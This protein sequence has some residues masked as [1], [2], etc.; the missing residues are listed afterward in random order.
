MNDHQVTELIEAIRQQTDAINRLASSNAALVQAMAEAE[1][2]DEEDQAPD[3][4]LDGAP[5]R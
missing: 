2:L 4:Y 5:C 3:T 1:G